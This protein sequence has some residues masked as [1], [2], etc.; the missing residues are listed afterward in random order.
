MFSWNKNGQTIPFSELLLIWLLLTEQEPST[1][2][3]AA[4]KRHQSQ[5]AESPD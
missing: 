1:N 2:P 5:S 4:F 3:G